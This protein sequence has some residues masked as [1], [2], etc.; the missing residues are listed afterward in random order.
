M[1]RIFIYG[2]YGFG[3]LGDDII[4]ET[5]LEDIENKVPGKKEYVIACVNPKGVM[6]SKHLKKKVKLISA[7]ERFIPFKTINEIN[8]SDVFILGGA[9]HLMGIQ[10]VLREVPRIY[11]S[12]FLE[13]KTYIWGVENGNYS[14][15]LKLIMKKLS[16]A[17]LITVRDKNSYDSLI[18]VG[19]KAPLV[20]AIDPVIHWKPKL[21]NYSKLLKKHNI[22]P[23]KPYTVVIAQI[24]AD[25]PRFYNIFNQK[26]I[27]KEKLDAEPKIAEKISKLIDNLIEKTDSQILFLPEEIFDEKLASDTYKFEL[28]KSYSKHKDKI[29]II[30]YIVEPM[31]FKYILQN[32]AMVLSERLHPIIISRDSYKPVLAI[33]NSYAKVTKFLK[34]MNLSNN[35]IDLA[36]KNEAKNKKLLISTY[37]DRAKITK[38]LKKD[39]PSKLKMS[40]KNNTVIEAIAK[41]K[42]TK[43]KSNILKKLLLYLLFL[44]TKTTWWFI[45]HKEYIVAKY[46]QKNKLIRL[47]LKNLEV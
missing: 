17:D 45:K 11:S 4:L 16:K 34:D 33:S 21:K 2:N 15:I 3:N 20:K 18:D 7:N 35:L 42:P 43:Y 14:G 22:N 40:N 12:I 24:K 23:K 39:F 46:F 31:Q 47:K 36:D 32:S 30:N 9:P 37:K 25:W 27:I 38:Q 28:I 13:K 6:L 41:I 8:K 1:V 5:L 29:N 26:V 44:A 19:I 10:G